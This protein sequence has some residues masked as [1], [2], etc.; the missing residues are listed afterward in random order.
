MQRLSISLI[1]IIFVS[2]NSF[3]QS[4]L[5]RELSSMAGKLSKSLNRHSNIQHLIIDDFQDLEKNITILGKHV[6][7]KFY[8]AI[9]DS[10]RSD[11]SILDRGQLEQTI[12]EIE[13]GTSGILDQG[14][15][16][17][18]GTLKGIDAI[19]TGVIT[20]NENYAN[21]EIKCV[22]LKTLSVKAVSNGRFLLTPTLKSYLGSVSNEDIQKKSN[23][24]KIIKPNKGKNFGPIIVKQCYCEN[25]QYNQLKCSLY[26]TTKES[27]SNL[28]FYT[29]KSYLY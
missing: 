2:V 19:I 13:F 16:L 4:Q 26:F 24:S 7:T 11:M 5:E 27:E 1:L 20:I 9:F 3:C 23:T 18:S 14:E 21:I 6:S 10:L 28:S 17:E 12:K 29:S 25:F 8:T 22:E 15:V